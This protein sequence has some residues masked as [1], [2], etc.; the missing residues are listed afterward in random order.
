MCVCVCMC[1]CRGAGDKDGG[2]PVEAI[3]GLEIQKREVTLGTQAGVHCPGPKAD[4]LSSLDEGVWS[5]NLSGPTF[6]I[7]KNGDYNCV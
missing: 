5:F 1:V 6:V 3:T 4:L 2:W 7:C